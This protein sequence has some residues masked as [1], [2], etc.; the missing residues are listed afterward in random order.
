VLGGLHSVEVSGEA[1]E[2]NRLYQGYAPGGTSPHGV[3]RAYLTEVLRMVESSEPFAVLAHIEYAVRGWPAGAGPFDPLSF[4]EE[5]RAVLREL[6]RSGRALEVNTSA[7]H[8]AQVIRWWHEAGGEAVS[9]G[10]D[11]HEPSNVARDFADAVAM[12]AS[13]GFRPGRD[14]N[15]FWVRGA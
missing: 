6:A 1:W 14:P 5:H 10:S 13:Q 9:F 12:V 11:A 2:A 4:E 15:D 8:H 7:P 3:V